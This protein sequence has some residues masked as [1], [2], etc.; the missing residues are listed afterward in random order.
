MMGLTTNQLSIV[1]KTYPKP[2][3]IFKKHMGMNLLLETVGI[4]LME[5]I[6]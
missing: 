6:L 1:P 2:I 3:L 4:A 5:P